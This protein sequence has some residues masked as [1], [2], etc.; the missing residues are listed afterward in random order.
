MGLYIMTWKEVQ[1]T[2]NEK[3]KQKTVCRVCTL[4]VCVFKCIEKYLQE[5]TLKSL[6]LLVVILR[7]GGK[8]TED[9]HCL[10]H[11]FLY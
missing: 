5:Y 2:L 3:T 10:C 7:T 6:L 9:F 11:T 1:V 8:V 4:I